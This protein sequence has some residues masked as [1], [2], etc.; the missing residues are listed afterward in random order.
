VSTVIIVCSRCHAHF[1]VL[2][3]SL[4]G[5]CLVLWG[6]PCHSKIT[7]SAHTTHTRTIPELSCL[8][9]ELFSTDSLTH[10]L[11]FSIS[12]LTDNTSP[13]F[14]SNQI[15]KYHDGY[16]MESS[17]ADDINMR[18]LFY[19]KWWLKVTTTTITLYFLFS[20]RVWHLNLRVSLSFSWY[21]CGF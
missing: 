3:F 15:A 20:N 9:P 11:H 16:S 19:P 7:H 8:L 10:S 2:L 5:V 1:F 4:L 17:S 21:L 13:R 6:V 12:N 14:P 18:A